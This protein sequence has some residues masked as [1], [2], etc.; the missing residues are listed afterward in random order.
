MLFITEN[1]KE[2]TVDFLVVQIIDKS[3]EFNTSIHRKAALS[4]AYTI[5]GAFYNLLIILERSK[6]FLMDTCGYAHDGLNYTQ[7]YFF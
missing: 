5:L 1:V 3:K 6:H 7:N 4:R 2:N